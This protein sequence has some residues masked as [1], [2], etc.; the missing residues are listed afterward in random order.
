MIPTIWASG[1][2]TK[3]LILKNLEECI[4]SGAKKLI[5]NIIV[6]ADAHCL[7]KHLNRTNLKQICHAIKE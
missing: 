7:S 1:I 6:F 5:E 3:L 4:N 2:L